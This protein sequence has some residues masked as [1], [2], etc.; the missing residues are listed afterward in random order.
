MN[1][2]DDNMSCVTGVT[3]TTGTTFYTQHVQFNLPEEFGPGADEAQSE[4]NIH[5]LNI[6]S[7]E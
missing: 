3:G 5:G 6:S 2:N 4:Y 7:T 1:Q